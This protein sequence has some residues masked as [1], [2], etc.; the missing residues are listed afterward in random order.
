PSGLASMKILPPEEVYFIAFPTR[1]S[2]MRSN[3]FLSTYEGRRFKVYRGMGSLGA[4]KKGARDR[5]MQEHVEEIDKMVPEGIEGRIPYRGPVSETVYQIEGGI[6]A[7]MGMA[8]AANLEEFRTKTQF[9]RVSFSG[10][11]ESHPHNIH[12]TKES[13]NYRTQ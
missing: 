7:G 2:K 6:R 4:M 5:Y 3:C 8:G 13:P 11:Q 9:C 1:L 10:L 12:I